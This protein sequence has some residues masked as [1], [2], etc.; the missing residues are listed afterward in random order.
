MGTL[1]ALFLLQETSITYTVVNEGT[2]I[3][4]KNIYY[5]N[6]Y[7]TNITTLLA[8]EILYNLN[9]VVHVQNIYIYIKHEINLITMCAVLQATGDPLHAL[10]L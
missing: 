3:N 6:K 8:Y 9:P 10:W 2:S 4:S 7:S 5:Y 1:L